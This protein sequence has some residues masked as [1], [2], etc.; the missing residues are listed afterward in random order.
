MYV[1]KAQAEIYNE[2]LESYGAGEGQKRKGSTGTVTAIRGFTAIPIRDGDDPDDIR[3][4]ETIHRGEAVKLRIEGRKDHQSPQRVAY[5]RSQD[6]FRPGHW[7]HTS[8]KG[9]HEVSRDVYRKH[10][11]RLEE[12]AEAAVG[13]V[14]EPVGAAVAKAQAEAAKAQ[15]A[16]GKAEAELERARVELAKAEAERDKAQAEAEAAKAAAA[17]T[18]SK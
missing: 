6:K 8:D 5:M 12:E 3:G 15:A 7:I 10:R 18:K 13:A 17:E 16:R 11:A 4:V 9:W 1:G 14:P 2:A